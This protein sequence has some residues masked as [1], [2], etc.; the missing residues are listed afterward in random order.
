MGKSAFEKAIQAFA[1]ANEWEAAELDADKAIFEFEMESGRTQTV[2]VIPYEDVVE[3]SVPS[4]ASFESEEDIPHEASTI[5]LQRNS[6]LKLGFWC[7]EEIEDEWCYEIMHNE[8]FEELDEENFAE[9]VE[10]LINEC[11]EF[12]GILEEMLEEGDN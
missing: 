11:D 10:A 2:Y 1:E 5:L 3:F 9:I 7:M 4:A 8:S 6:Q 12:E